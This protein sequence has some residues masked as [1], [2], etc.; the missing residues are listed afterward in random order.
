[1]LA[2]LIDRSAL[3]PCL[4]AVISVDAARVFKPDPRAYA[5]VEAALCAAPQDVVFISSNGFDASGAKAFG[6]KVA[7][8]ERLPAASLRAE[9]AAAATID[10]KTMYK[11]L[12]V[13]RETMGFI[14]DVVISS[15]AELPAALERVA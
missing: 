12:R 5:L 4:E 2:A 8:I 3:R 10:P 14:P 15:L 11:A 1:M 6:F 9:I 13:Q 7:H